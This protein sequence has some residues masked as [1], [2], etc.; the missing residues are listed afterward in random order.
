MDYST[1]E[2]AIVDEVRSHFR[3]DHQD[4]V[5]AGNVDLL[6]NQLL[7]GGRE[8]GVL[9]EFGGGVRRGRSEEEPFSGRIWQWSVIAVYMLRYKGNTEEIE[10]KLRESIDRISSLFPDHTLGGLTPWVRLERIDQPE[11]VRMN[12]LPLYWIPFEIMVFEKA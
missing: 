12:D 7:E 1:L 10:A 11:I 8:Y 4:Q 5:V 3:V 9:L 2:T 6:L